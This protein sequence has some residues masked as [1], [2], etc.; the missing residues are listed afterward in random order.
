MTSSNKEWP[1]VCRIVWLSGGLVAINEPGALVKIEVGINGP[2]YHE[3]RLSSF[4]SLFQT[5]SQLGFSVMG[6]THVVDMDEANGIRSPEFRAWAGGAQTWRVSDMHQQWNQVAHV[7]AKKNEMALMDVASRISS[8]LGY[9]EMRL[10]N[11]AE[12]Y[13]AQLSGKAKQGALKEFERFQDTHSLRVYLAIHA[14]FWELAV[15]RDYLAEFAA[16]FVFG[17]EKIDTF[18]GLLTKLPKCQNENLAMELLTAGKDDKTGWIAVF[19][20]YRNLFT[21]SAPMEQAA[22][23]AFATLD[24]MAF[25]GGIKIPQLYYPLPHDARDIKNRRSSGVLYKNMDELVAISRKIPIRDTE[26]DALQYLHTT[27]VQ[28]ATLAEKLIQRSHIAPEIIHFTDADIVGSVQI[29]K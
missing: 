9:S 25:M 14:L 3:F 2:T 24:H 4:G 6:A 29:I 20:A 7:A 26:P 1:H 16:K 17:F 10:Q 18:S 19:T 12:A 22:G 11:L 5:L 21:H 28:M 27:L 13:S 23:I 15:L 8:E